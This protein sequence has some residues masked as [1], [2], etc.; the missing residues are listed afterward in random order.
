VA[1][2]GAI[3]NETIKDAIQEVFLFVPKRGK[4]TVDP[5]NLILTK[6]ESAQNIK[7]RTWIERLLRLSLQLFTSNFKNK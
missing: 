2:P 7:N 3:S 4:N 1:V 6:E 5:D